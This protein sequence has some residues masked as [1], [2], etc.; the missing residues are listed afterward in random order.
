ML[1]AESVSKVNVY[2]A[3]HHGSAYSS[4][5]DLLRVIKPEIAVISCGKENP[6][7]HPADSTIKRLSEYT[8]NIYR[9]DIC[10]TIVKES[11]GKKLALTPERSTK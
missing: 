4:T 3:G 8:Q 6:Y 2:K 5:Y 10:G 1:K 11:D 7:G 9:T